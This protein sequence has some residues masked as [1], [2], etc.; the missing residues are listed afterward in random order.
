MSIALP[1]HDDAVRPRPRA[2]GQPA[3]GRGGR[4]HP[5]RAR[6]T[7]STSST[8]CAAAPTCA[9]RIVEVRAETHQSATIVHQ[10]GPRLDRPRARPVR[11][12]RRRRRRGPPLAHLLPDPRPA[13]RPL[14]QHHRQGDPR[15]RRLQ[16]P[17]PPRPRRPD[18]PARPGR[19][20][21]S[22][23]RSRS[24]AKLLLVTAGSGITPVIG[25]LRN[26]FSRAE[27]PQTDIVLLHSALVAR[28]GRSSATSC[29]STPPPAGCASSSCTPTPTACS[30]STTSTRSSPTSTERTA[31]ACGPA[32]LLDALEEH[33]DERGL[34]LTTERFRPATVVAPARA[35]PSPSPTAR[36]SR[37]TAPPRSST[38]RRTPAS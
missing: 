3:P 31:Y 36:S 30:T 14:H 11:P 10:A 1:Y 32:G 33:Y 17:R 24:P 15:R 27:R 35:A 23:S 34:V 38:R 7:S 16:L 12:R 25:M 8:R 28:R 26:L 13:R 20:A 29:V 37:P 4:G 19:R 2:A 18:D 22:C 6:A 5:A 9:A 21:S